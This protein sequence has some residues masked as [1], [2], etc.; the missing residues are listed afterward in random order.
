MN[1]DELFDDEEEFADYI[2]AEFFDMNIEE[3]IKYLISN[4]DKK[5]YP[6]DVESNYFP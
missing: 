2:D 6:D 1:N 5:I 4:P 3:Q